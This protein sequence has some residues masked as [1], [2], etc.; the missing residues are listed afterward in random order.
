MR[1]RQVV[2]IILNQCCDIH[3]IKSP[4]ASKVAVEKLKERSRTSSIPQQN[5]HAQN[6]FSESS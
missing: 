4:V 6:N 5:P 1:G 2:K 3:I